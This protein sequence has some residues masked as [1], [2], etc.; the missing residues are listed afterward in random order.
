MANRRRGSRGQGL[1]TVLFTDLAGST[2]LTQR[3]GDAR[4]QE[5]VRAHNTIVRREV[6][7]R[8]GTEI[9]HTGDGIMATFPSAARAVAS[10]VAIQ[11]GVRTYGETHPEMAFAVKI[12]LN[13]GEPL[14]EDADVFGTA[15]QLAAR[16]CAE[17]KAGQILAT[18]V[19]RELVF[20]KGALFGDVGT[21]ELKGFG[22]PVRLFEVGVGEAGIDEGAELA[23]RSLLRWG[24][25]GALAV[26]L[27]GLGAAALILALTGGDDAG[28]GNAPAYRELRSRSSA[29][30]ALTVLD[31]DCDTADLRLEGVITGTWQGDI[32]GNYLGDSAVSLDVSDECRSSRVE[33]SMIIADDEGNRFEGRAL[34]FAAPRIGG[35]TGQFVPGSTY[36]VVTVGAVTGGAGVYKDAIG[37]YQCDLLAT[38]QEGLSSRQDGDCTVRL[39]LEDAPILVIAAGAER[40]SVGV[41]LNTR[42]EVDTVRLYGVYLNVSG[43]PMNGA[44]MR[45]TTSDDVEFVVE[46]ADPATSDPAGNPAWD[47]PPIPAGDAVYFDLTLRL[48]SSQTDTFDVVIEVQS[49]E[50]ADPAVS[51]PVT[52][53]VVR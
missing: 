7:T 20:G 16:T 27:V 26:A 40:R 1:L 34:T 30:T 17:A 31:G 12:G 45:I 43:T 42:Q 10:A 35:I 15:V 13:A 19:V 52:L 50:L 41:S 39:F 29:E 21:A 44:Q 6:Q 33:T 11:Q 32:S 23:A 49:D 47:I 25:A 46:R 3:L 38:T 4:A 9:K 51:L 14:A 24:A 22:E 2:A 53:E 5:V 28:A 18:N 37:T 8:G 36:E 48:R